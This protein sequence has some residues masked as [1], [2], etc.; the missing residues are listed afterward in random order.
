MVK[1]ISYAILLSVL[2][3]AF[4][5]SDLV[6]V[7][8]I[9]VKAESVATDNLS[10]IYLLNNDVL[11]KYDPQGSPLKSY[12]NKTLGKITTVDASNPMKVVL[13]YRNFLQ[14]VFLDNTLSQN[15]D[16]VSIE[17]LGY[18]Q[19]QLVCSSHNNGIWIYNLQNFELIRFDQ[20]LQVVSQTGNLMQLLG[21]ELKPNYMVE[22]NNH[23]YVNNPSAGILVFDVFGTYSKTI[24]LKNIESFQ[25]KEDD[26]V[27]Y[28]YGK[29]NSF[30]TQTL[31]QNESALPDTAAIS[32]KLSNKKLY[33]LQK[34]ALGI[35]VIK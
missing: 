27:Y 24:P 9:P 19:T 8:S 25:F 31:Q 29:L 18:P 21:I 34:D 4:Q 15:G 12:S 20:N 13:F 35:Y 1:R 6:F 11:Q 7:K 30:N 33:V 23:L 14:I 5:Q 26:I 3:F 22:Y 17:N 32:V 10:N 2:F 16:P 28:Q